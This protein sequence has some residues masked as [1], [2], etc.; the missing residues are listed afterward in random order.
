MLTRFF[1]FFI[2]GSALLIAAG[3]IIAFFFHLNVKNSTML[4]AE[5]ERL[6]SGGTLE[7]AT[8]EMQQIGEQLTGQQ[9]TDN[10]WP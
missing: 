10:N 6:R 7:D 3:I 8:E 2:G 9:W 4:T 5:L 1:I